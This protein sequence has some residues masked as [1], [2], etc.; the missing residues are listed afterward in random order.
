MIV[1]LCPGQGSQKPGF[2]S[3]WLEIDSFKANLESFSETISLDLVKH[4]TISDEAT[5]RDTAIA[6]PLIVAASMATANLL[7]LKAVSGVAGHSVGEVA[8]S[9]ISG[10]LT[11]SEAIR[12]VDIRA[13]AMAEAAKAIQGTGM[14]AV[15]GGEQE[16]VLAKLNELGLAAAN[17]NGAGQIVAAGSSEKIQELISNAPLGSKIIPLSVAGAFHTSF[18]EAASQTLKGFVQTLD[19]K[20]PTMKLWSNQNGQL[21][22]DGSEFLSLVVGQVANSVRWDLCMQA[23]LEA[24]VT[25][26][27]ELSPAGALAGLAKRGMPGLNIVALK[28]PEDLEAARELIASEGK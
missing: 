18:M 1:L 27:I 25:G 5:I 10:I 17:Y 9:Y 26:V 22:T 20:N 13:Q 8:A 21:V 3:N 15:L 14:A 2:L 6:Q 16:L 23:M 28:Q 7:N 11:E 24:G 4:G 19:P 12:L